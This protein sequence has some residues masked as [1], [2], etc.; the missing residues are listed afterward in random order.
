[1][2][3]ACDVPKRTTY[4]EADC[5]HLSQVHEY[6]RSKL[7]SLYENDCIF[8]KFEC[9]WNSSDSVIMTGAYNSFFRMF[10]RETG[11]GVTLEA[12]RE[13]SK[14]RAV[15]RTRRVYTGGKR[16]RG[17][18]GVDSLDFTKKILHMAWHP[19]ENII[20]IA[21]T[22]NLYIFQDRVNP[23]AQTQ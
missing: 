13:N 22:N 8:D 4:S 12:W 7:C 11:R 23:D 3:S 21:A 10:D 15:L 18:V 19:A 6:L 14:P 5:L 20:A 9:V 2:I 17:D 16:R 1:M